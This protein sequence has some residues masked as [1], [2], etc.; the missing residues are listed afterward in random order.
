MFTE[1]D[2]TARGTNPFQLR[3]M[4]SRLLEIQGESFDFTVK[5]RQPRNEWMLIS[6]NAGILQEVWD[7]VQYKK[8]K[9]T[10]SDSNTQIYLSDEEDNLVQSEK[11]VMDTSVMGGTYYVEFGPN[12]N[13]RKIDL[14]ED[15]E[16]K[17]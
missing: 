6:P 14:K 5:I 1:K 11:G 12:L 4:V 2:F 9:I 17:E 7:S 16:I 3:E 10:A 13:K 8:L 15:M